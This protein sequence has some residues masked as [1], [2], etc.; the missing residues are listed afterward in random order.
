MKLPK[1]KERYNV[2]NLLSAVGSGIIGVLLFSAL[3]S[4]ALTPL[5][6]TIPMI[7]FST[8]IVL[9]ATFGAVEK[10][11]TYN[12]K[13]RKS[14]TWADPIKVCYPEDKEELFTQTI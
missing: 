9:S 10:I 12:T 7:A 6:I 4:L 14:V 8:I 2:Y 5:F 1:G 3:G 13:S 11:Y